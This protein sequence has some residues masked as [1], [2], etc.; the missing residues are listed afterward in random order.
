V[1][2]GR[3]AIRVANVNHRSRTEDFDLLVS[4]VARIGAEVA[5]QESS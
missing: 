4:A 1:L 3:Y 2:A 5:G